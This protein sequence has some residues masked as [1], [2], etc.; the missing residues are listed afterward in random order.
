[1]YLHNEQNTTG[2]T[3]A[4]VRT[5]T[6]S[7]WY[8]KKKNSASPLSLSVFVSVM[9]PN[10]RPELEAQHESSEE[11]EEDPPPKTTKKSRSD[12]T[13][14]VS[15]KMPAAENNGGDRESIEEG[16]EEEA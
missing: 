1:M 6:T 14:N 3:T 13:S 5:E 15:V 4:D 10:R 8:W 9:A 2:D 11:E 7:F 12:R 16:E